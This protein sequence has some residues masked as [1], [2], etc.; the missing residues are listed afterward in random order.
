MTQAD[1]TPQ[2]TNQSGGTKPSPFVLV[3]TAPP[4]NPCLTVTLTDTILRMVGSDGLIDNNWLAAGIAW[5]MRFQAAPAEAAALRHDT[6]TILLGLPVDINV[7]SDDPAT[8]RKKLLVADMDSTIIE[9][10][11][12]DEI[13]G[14][15]GVRDAVSGIT[16]RAM[17]GELDFEDALRERVSLLAGLPE[18]ALASVIEDRLT[19]MPGGPQLIATMRSSGA[20][21]ALV[22]GGFT[23][24]TERIAAQVGFNTHR[25]NTLIIENEKLSGTVSEPIL[26]R[27][28][29][30]STLDEL[31]TLHGI[32]LSETLAVGD[33]ANDLGMIERAGLGV[34]YRAKPV[35]AV[36]AGV[37]INAC[38]LTALLYLQGYSRDEFVYG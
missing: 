9:Q 8:R 33:G 21:C 6:A 20:Y 38:D 23:Y 15:A 11:C 30:R 26:G 32:T 1:R 31:A 17:R 19:L 37:A 4:L 35:V 28:A 16:E 5:E 10:E 29:K 36:A 3:V 25:A 14:L 22:S 24:F 13:A 7:L 12:I 27:E 2:T 18:S 34:A